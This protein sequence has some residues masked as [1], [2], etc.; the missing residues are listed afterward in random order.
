MSES[1]EMRYFYL[2]REVALSL[3]D[4]AYLYTRGERPTFDQIVDW[5]ADRR[6]L[7]EE[8]DERAALILAHLQYSAF[9]ES[10]VQP[11]DVRA[12]FATAE[13]IAVVFALGA[14]AA[15][16]AHFSGDQAQ[17]HAINLE[18]AA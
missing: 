5:V 13:P 15:R 16:A 2:H 12:W 3:T 8:R 10:G 17:N 7:P 18:S 14:A 6:G 9:D 11:R 4:A 1:I